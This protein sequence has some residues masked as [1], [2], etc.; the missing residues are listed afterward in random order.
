MTIIY[1]FLF[2]FFIDF[3]FIVLLQVTVELVDR[4]LMTES[5][6][7]NVGVVSVGRIVVQVPDRVE[8]TKTIEAIVRLYDSMDNLMELDL[9][10]L[11]VYQLHEDVFNVNIL[12]VK[13]DQHQHNLN[14]GEIR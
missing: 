10:N 12:T 8:K 11:D 3:F 7:L 5:S 2:L 9:S 14:V 13:L 4:C 6:V 1:I